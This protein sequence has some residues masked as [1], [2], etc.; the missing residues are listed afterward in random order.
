MLSFIG[1]EGDGLSGAKLS[2]VPSGENLSSQ[3]TN[4]QV[5][6]LIYYII[7]IAFTNFIL[8]ILLLI[9]KVS[10][11]TIQFQEQIYQYKF[12]FQKTHTTFK[13]RTEL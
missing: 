8:L 11:I 9:L 6:I 2:L 10:F 3:G 5:E 1:E 12:V 13:Y 7:S 4:L